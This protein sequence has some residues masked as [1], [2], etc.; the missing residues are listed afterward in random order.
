MRIVDTLIV[1]R[2][3]KMLTTPFNKMKAYK[4]GFIDKSGN[5]I[6]KIEDENGKMVPNDPFTKAEKSSLTPLHRLVFNLKRL[7]CKIPF[8]KSVLASW[9]TALY[10]LKENGKMTDQQLKDAL[11][12]LVDFDWESLKESSDTWIQTQGSLNPGTYILTEDVL[13]P[14]TGEML[15]YKNSKV[16]VE[17]FTEPKGYVFN[18][19]IYEVLHILTK[20]KL[21]ISI[22]EIK[23]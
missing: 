14:V 18:T 13:S 20:Q 8:G 4:F 9:A 6:K 22:G 11:D 17:D 19:P 15:G 23:R 2:I 21:Y 12:D 3:L 10:L 16:L 7:V 1:F 5:R